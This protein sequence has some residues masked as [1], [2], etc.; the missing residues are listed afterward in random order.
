MYR[1]SVSRR[2][3]PFKWLG[4]IPAFLTRARQKPKWYPELSLHDSS[5]FPGLPSAY[6]EQ[7]RAPDFSEYEM[8]EA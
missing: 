4:D 5:T 2:A 8:I 6:H 7:L 3:L 1:A